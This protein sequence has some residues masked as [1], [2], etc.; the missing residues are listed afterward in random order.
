MDWLTP[1]LRREIRKVFEPKYKY[2]LSEEEVEE[3]AENLSGV[4]ETILKFKWRQKYD[5]TESKKTTG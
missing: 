1:E 3:I 4:I 2:A 5:N